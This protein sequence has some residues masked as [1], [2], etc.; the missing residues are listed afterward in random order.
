MTAFPGFSFQPDED[1]N[2]VRKLKADQ[3]AAG[4][5]VVR[6]QAAQQQP[7]QQGQYGAYAPPQPAPQQQSNT[8]FSAYQP[9]AQPQANAPYSAYQYDPNKV[10]AH[11]GS[12]VRARTSGGEEVRDVDWEKQNAWWNSLTDQQRL[13]LGEGYGPGNKSFARPQYATV[14]QLQQAEMWR[15]GDAK[16]RSQYQA[17]RDRLTPQTT[18]EEY[19]QAMLRNRSD[20]AV[21]EMIQRAK[22]DASRGLNADFTQSADYARGNFESAMALRDK[23]IRG[24]TSMMENPNSTPEQ[25]AKLQSQLDAAM[26]DT[27]AQDAYE[28]RLGQ[29]R[30]NYDRGMKMLG[31]GWIPNVFRDDYAAKL[32]S[33]G[34]EL[35][36]LRSGQQDNEFARFALRYMQSNP[37]LAAPVGVDPG[38]AEGRAA[39][40]EYAKRPGAA[41]EYLRSIGLNDALSHYGNLAKANKDYSLHRQNPW[42]N[43]NY[44]D[45]LVQ[46]L[47][48]YA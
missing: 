48:M 24:L 20:P 45:G 7:A 8:P 13:I 33:N 25:R 47:A 14:S 10:Y 46:R 15:A 4:F 12:E 44:T 3:P 38:T 43:T 11:F 17:I 6:Q 22:Q 18:E 39:M 1:G 2:A 29:L 34:A 41:N 9:Q 5:P 27:S 35:A 36:L 23:R 37:G 26:A 40:E 31:E 32:R 19:E 16:E 42:I 30:A 28:Q 21:Q